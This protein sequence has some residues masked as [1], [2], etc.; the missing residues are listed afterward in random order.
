MPRP[1]RGDGRA[2]PR[3]RAA[4]SSPL[5]PR[6]VLEA[7]T[8]EEALARA[9]DHL[10]ARLDA[11]DAVALVF[12][13]E[14]GR[15]HVAARRGDDDAFGG[16]IVPGEGPAG[17]AFSAH[18]ERIEAGLV[19]LPLLAFGRAHG[20]FLL[21][22]APPV[23]SLLQEARG[24]AAIAAH[25]LEISRARSA[26]ELASA[27]D[28]NDGPSPAEEARLF[29]LAG[30]LAAPVMT[31]RAQLPAAPGLLDETA[32]RE[33]RSALDRI[34]HL[35]DGGLLGVRLAAAGLSPHPRPFPLRRAIE[36][37][38]LALG[39]DGSGATITAPGGEPLVRGDAARLVEALAQLF[40]TAA[41]LGDGPPEIE[42]CA[43]LARGV[44][45]V[46]V[47]GAGSLHAELLTALEELPH[48]TSSSA[49]GLTIARRVARLHGGELSLHHHGD[50]LEFELSLPS[51]AASVPDVPSGRPGNVGL[52]VADESLR[53]TLA[54]LLRR[55]G[56][57]VTTW[58]DMAQAAEGV[59][60]APPALLLFD[61]A[62]AGPGAEAL[63]QA[64]SG[65]APILALGAGPF[66]PEVTLG[67]ALDGVVALP[68]DP[69]ALLARVRAFV[70]PPSDVVDA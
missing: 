2:P 57:A 11:D 45:R 65:R 25:A 29:A 22:A 64:A 30:A 46:F 40:V 54:T 13:P 27:I 56:H 14:H 15:L 5:P 7:P 12:E 70:V 38:L 60:S 61:T 6:L 24:L 68:A 42:L 8:P 3:R 49:V 35:C 34:T 43:R 52:A 31:L 67:R 62:L 21:R 50:R 17:R 16:P 47:R 66:A 33:L 19:A 23:A 44:V 37:A 51:F 59:R 26:A 63:L 53:R 18:E 48:L 9:L 4:A 20:A 55:D 69:P 28:P 36:E 41:R 32:L 10:C 58:D 1:P 39:P